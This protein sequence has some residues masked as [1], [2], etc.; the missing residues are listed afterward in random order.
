M[1]TRV[2][3]AVVISLAVVACGK[4]KFETV[5]KLSVKSKSTDVVSL[6]ENFRVTLEY[7]DKE[8]DVSDSLIIVRKR[9][10]RR[11]PV[12]PPPSPYK[13]PEFPN[14]DKGQFEV[15]FRYIQDLTFNIGRIRIPGIS[16]DQFEPDTMLLKFV[17]RDKAGNKS[18]TATASVI[19]KRQ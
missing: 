4:D 11:M 1:K 17:A 8:G 3:L 5:P 16:P 2:I 10:N 7:T 18:D 9:L 15:N 13:I 6:N 12:T 14:T 19:V